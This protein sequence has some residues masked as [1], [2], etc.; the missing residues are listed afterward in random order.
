MPR[1]SPVLQRL[2]GQHYSTISQ[3]LSQPCWGNSRIA[4][5]MQMTQQFRRFANAAMQ[6]ADSLA[7][8]VST[9]LLAK[10]RRSVV[11]TRLPFE[12]RVVAC[13]KCLFQKVSGLLRVVILLFLFV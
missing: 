5:K 8:K 1:H 9:S 10:S 7:K 3:L 2:L 11:A 13:L 6:F 4:T 12:E